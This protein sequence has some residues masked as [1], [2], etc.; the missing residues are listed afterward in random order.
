MTF[1]DVR[2]NWIY[3][4]QISSLKRQRCPQRFSYIRKKELIL[5]MGSGRWSFI[6]W[7]GKELP[8]SF[9]VYERLNKTKKWVHIVEVYRELTKKVCS[10]LKR[11]IEVERPIF[12]IFLLSLWC[13]RGSVRLQD[14]GHIVKWAIIVSTLYNRFYSFWNFTSIYCAY[15]FTA[16]ILVVVVVF[17][18]F[19]REF[20]TYD[21]HS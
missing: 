10:K 13:G 3:D 14:I 1:C 11:V 8:S 18:F 21:F 12:S 5:L 20:S 9:L 4:L 6:G 15:N 7:S 19:K 16:I 2:L 17:F